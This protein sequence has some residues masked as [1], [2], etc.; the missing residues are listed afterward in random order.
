MRLSRF[1]LL[2]SL[3]CL[4]ASVTRLY[5]QGKP[6]PV[7][8]FAGAPNYSQAELLAFTGLKPGSTQQQMDAA[9]QRLGDTGLFDEV[10]FAG[11]NREII[12]TLKPSKTTRSAS[13]SNFI[14]WPDEE[15][16]R[17]L[18]ARVPLYRSSAVPIRG[19]MDQEIKDTLTALLK[20]KGI[21]DA[22]ISL[23]SET[24]RLVF[25][26][27][28]PPVRI[29]ALRIEGVSAAMQPKI[30]HVVHE[31]TGQLWDKESIKDIFVRVGDDYRNE[32]YRDVTLLKQEHSAPAISADGIDLDMTATISE[33]A[34]YHVSQFDWA[35]S[36]VL[37]PTGFK[38]VITLKVGSLD[39]AYSLQ[40]SLELIAR[41]YR[42]KGYTLAKASAPPVVD[43]ATHQV[44]YTASVVPGPLHH[45]SSV[46]FIGISDELAKQLNAAWQMKPG[47][48]YDDSYASRFVNQNPAWSKQGYIPIVQA[49]LEPV[50][51]T[52]DITINFSRV[53]PPKSH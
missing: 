13:Y 19:D 43:S 7:I 46:H 52:A 8:S 16:D 48:I 28:S 45:F 5:S 17:D 50:A 15:L 36:E 40:E 4:C 12:F 18:R 33:G 32:G 30:D 35:G 51:H 10:N 49:K 25:S 38:K 41:A 22:S 53:P 37:S 21:V 6:S 44:S 39:S 11:N 23:M 31:M 27:A 24:S 20:E 26:I 47:D 29:H 14:F 1:C 3:L 2:L 9:A 42:A 34:Q